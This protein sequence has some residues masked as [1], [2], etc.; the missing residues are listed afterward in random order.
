MAGMGR[1]GL[2]PD[3]DGGWWHGLDRTRVENDLLS[4]LYCLYYWAICFHM[5]EKR[6]FSRAALG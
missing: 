5:L 2:L 3:L 4:Y 1:V 6:S